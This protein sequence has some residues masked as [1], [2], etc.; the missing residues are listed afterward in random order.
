M[1]ITEFRL[2]LVCYFTT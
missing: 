2:I 1:L